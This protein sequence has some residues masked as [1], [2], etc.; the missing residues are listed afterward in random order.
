MLG[1]LVCQGNNQVSVSSATANVWLRCHWCIS[2][3]F[4]QV[5]KQVS[6]NV[7]QLAVPCPG[8]SSVHDFQLIGPHAQ[9]EVITLILLYF[10]ISVVIA[11]LVRI[12]GA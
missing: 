5:E 1:E 7:I 9:I 10:R 12:I 3:I 4:V 11:S 8:C 2:V 6:G